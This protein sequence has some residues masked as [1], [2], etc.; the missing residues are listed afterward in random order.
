L[1]AGKPIQMLLALLAIAWLAVTVVVVALCHAAARGDAH[2]A[3]A[4]L[5]PPEL[6]PAD[7]AVWG[8]AGAQAWAASALRPRREL[9]PGR[10][11][12]R[13]LRRARRGWRVPQG[14]R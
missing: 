14:I 3:Q 10:A 5:D 11:R 2:H 12:L 9:E 1:P 8:P 4:A 6:I 7:L 13:R